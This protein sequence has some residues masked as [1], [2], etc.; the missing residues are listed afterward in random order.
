MDAWARK[1]GQQANF[2]CVG[3]AGAQQAHMMK[4]QMRL[5]HCTVGFVAERKDMP[6]WG[7]L[8]CNGFIVLDKDLRVVSRATAPFNMVRQLGFKHVETLVDCLLKGESV[9]T[10]C[11]GQFVRLTS[12]T[13]R[14]ELNG[15]LGM[16][17]DQPVTHS[18]SVSS[19][20]L[21]VR[22]PIKLLQ[23]PRTGATSQQSVMAIKLSNLKLEADADAVM[24]ELEGQHSQEGGGGS[25]DDGGCG[26]CGGSTGCVKGKEEDKQQKQKR[27]KMEG[28]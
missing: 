8:G 18:S 10:V 27:K 6:R 15:L 11:P 25:C 7:Q 17:I 20:Q 5:Q 16:C 3:C 14:P 9:P 26:D 2:L 4:T 13:T 23:P 21:D 22:F 19:P 24:E 28:G 1:Y 12:L